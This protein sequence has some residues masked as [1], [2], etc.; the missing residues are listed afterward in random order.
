[1]RERGTTYNNSLWKIKVPCKKVPCKIKIFLWY[2]QKGV[3]LTKDNLAKRKWKRSMGCCSSP[4]LVSGAE[5]WSQP[6]RFDSSLERIMGL[7]FKK[8]PSP[9][10]RGSGVF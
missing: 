9:M 8:N 4:S 3:V 5:L 1:M 7:I 6:P 10:N 2:L